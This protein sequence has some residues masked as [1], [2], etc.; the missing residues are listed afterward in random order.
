MRAVIIDGNTHRS[1]DVAQGEGG[2]VD[3]GQRADG[4]DDG[5]RGAA[6]HGEYGLPGRARIIHQVVSAAA[7]PL[8]HRQHRVSLLRHVNRCATSAH[9]QLGKAVNWCSAS[10]LAAHELH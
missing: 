8:A 10:P 4:L 7:Q 2:G 6:L 3:A 5:G 1:G 9:G